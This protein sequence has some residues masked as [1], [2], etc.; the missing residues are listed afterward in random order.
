MVSSEVRSFSFE[1]RI[2]FGIQEKRSFLKESF[3][4]ETASSAFEVELFRL[5][6]GAIASTTP[7]R[8]DRCQQHVGVLPVGRL[9]VQLVPPVDA[10]VQ[11]VDALDPE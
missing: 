9:V 3:P 1:V 7:N 6:A 8:L 4:F 5:K 2:A 11:P 10:L